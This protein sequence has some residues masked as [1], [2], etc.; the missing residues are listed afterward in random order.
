[1]IVAEAVMCVDQPWETVI[2]DRGGNWWREY[3]WD[4]SPRLCICEHYT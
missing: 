2:G 4:N 1:V 3:I